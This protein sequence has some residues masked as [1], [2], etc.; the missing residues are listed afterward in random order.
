MGKMSKY[1]G[2][3]NLKE[4]NSKYTC[5]SISRRIQLCFI[6]VDKVRLLYWKALLNLDTKMQSKFLNILFGVQSAVTILPISTVLH[7][8]PKAETHDTLYA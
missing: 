8:V 4:I 7:S 5:I 2:K 6:F 1:T 3:L